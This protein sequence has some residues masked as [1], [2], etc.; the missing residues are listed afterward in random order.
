MLLFVNPK[1]PGINGVGA[2]DLI[3]FCIKKRMRTTCIY[4]V[5]NIGVNVPVDLIQGYESIL[6]MRSKQDT[7][8]QFQSNYNPN[9][10]LS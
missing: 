2:M 7:E 8:S 10:I 9:D 6:D 3:E 1:V 4:L 5:D